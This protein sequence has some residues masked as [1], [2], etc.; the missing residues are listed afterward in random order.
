MDVT[1][2]TITYSLS[3]NPDGL[4]QIDANTGVITTAAAIDRETVGASR[5]VT[6]LA[7]SSD[8]SSAT[9]TFS[10]IIN[11]LDEFNVSTP[12]DIDSANNWIAEN[13]ANGTA[14]G[15]T[16][17]AV[18]YDATSNSIT[19]A[20]ADDAGGRFA[21]DGQTGVVTVANSSLFNYELA[22]SHTIVVQALSSD[23]STS[24]QTMSI[25]IVNANEAPS[26][27]ALGFTTNNVQTLVV[28]GSQ[29]TSGM[30][31]PMV[32]R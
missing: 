29:V 21:I 12:I 4:F 25:V 11:D 22:T 32:T 2:N 30:T 17:M 16:A 23:G 27:T 24:T 8:G 14:V 10:I 20:L 1:T 9:Q 31:D 18:D 26:A 19:Y 13:V 15:I 3:T 6:V 7:Q 5:S 28:S